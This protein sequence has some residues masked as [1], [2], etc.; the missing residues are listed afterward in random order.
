MTELSMITSSAN[1]LVKHIRKLRER[2]EREV[3]GLFYVE[4]LRIVAELAEKAGQI[5]TLLVCPELLSGGFGRELLSKLIAGG[6]PVVNFSPAVFESFSLKDGPQG[7]AALA[8]QK[9][10]PLEQVNPQVGECWVVLEAVADPGNLGTILRTLDAVGGQGV[11]LLEQSTDPY[12]PT[13]I[14]AS[15]GA[16]FAQHLVKT[17]LAQF[18]DWARAANWHIVGTS[19]A[20]VVDYHHTQYPGPFILMMGSE[21]HGLSSQA[22]ELCDQMVS[23]PMLGRGDSLNLAVATAVVLYE[24][25]NK[26]RDASAGGNI[27]KG[28]ESK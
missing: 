19:D 17:T 11:I 6:V 22:M 2:K 5:E 25:L 7:M 8:H 10:T 20:A 13:A 24:W 4:G 3:S 18:S 14:R 16:V 15:M 27:F 9:W 21:R 28:D 23:I 1:P 12:D 26:K